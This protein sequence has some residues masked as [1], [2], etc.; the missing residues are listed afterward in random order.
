MAELFDE[1]RWPSEEHRRRGIEVLGRE[2][3]RLRRLVESLLDFARMEAGAAHY[4]LEPL[5]PGDLVRSTVE[6][7]RRQTASR[8]HEI[9]LAVAAELPQIE[10]DGEAL[11]RAVWNLLDN[12]VKYSPDAKAVETDVAL[13]EDRLA[14]S[15]RDRG[16]GI[17][18][19]EQ[20]QIF[21]KFVRGSQAKARGLKG[22]GI[23][24]TMVRHIVRGHRG[25]IRLD[26]EPGRGSTFTILLP[27]RRM[28]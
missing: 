13:R 27:A 11:G 21:Q 6:G 2:S 17:A 14:I 18:P 24:L 10:A 25:E 8:R 7:F 15:V 12:A 22:T 3:A 23:G 4:R 5:D 1:D 28:A 16:I 26:S 9:Q 20:H 19:E